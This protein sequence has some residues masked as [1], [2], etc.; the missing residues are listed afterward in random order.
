MEI[1]NLEVD[2]YS[3]ILAALI[4]IVLYNTNLKQATD[5]LHRQLQMASPNGQLETTHTLN[6]AV[7][8]L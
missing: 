1:L 4:N 7:S 5:E 8:L 2:S 3:T 6:F